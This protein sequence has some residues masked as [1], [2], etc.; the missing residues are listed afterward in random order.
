MVETMRGW[1]RAVATL[2]SISAL[3]G[4]AASSASAQGAMT[5]PALVARDASD[6]VIGQ[7]VDTSGSFGFPVV[8][9]EIDDRKTLV[10]LATEFFVPSEDTPVYYP[11]SDCAGAPMVDSL[12]FLP[13]RALRTYIGW[14]IVG[15]APLVGVTDA[16]PGP[17]H[18]GASSRRSVP[19][20]R[21]RHCLADRIGHSTHCCLFGR[22]AR[23]VSWG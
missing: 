15:V 21:R 6:Q 4:I 7:V 5:I 16:P 10:Q 12:V 11:G 9:L 23:G 20:S 8:L 2:A 17:H 13:D 14:D 19:Y 18:T 1:K 3:L 22:P